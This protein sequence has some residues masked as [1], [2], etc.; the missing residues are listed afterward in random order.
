MQILGFAPH[1]V[2]ER[3]LALQEGSGLAVPEATA[4]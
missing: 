4:A 3:V 2:K 1:A